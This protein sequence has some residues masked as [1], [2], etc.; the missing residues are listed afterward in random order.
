MLEAS[1]KVIKHEIGG[2]LIPG[3]GQGAAPEFNAI[4]KTTDNLKHQEWGR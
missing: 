1:F 4:P 2:L 3:P